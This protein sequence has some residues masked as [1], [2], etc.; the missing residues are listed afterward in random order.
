[1]CKISR[2][3]KS[4]FY[5]KSYLFDALV[6]EIVTFLKLFINANGVPEIQ[7][8]SLLCCRYVLDGRTVSLNG[9][10]ARY[11]EIAWRG[12]IMIEIIMGSNINKS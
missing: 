11:P 4:R 6:I 3:I 10:I 1:M 12:Y 8:L 9:K 2:R 7:K 5:I